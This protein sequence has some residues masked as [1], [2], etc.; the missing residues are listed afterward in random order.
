MSLEDA[1]GQ[2]MMFGFTGTEVTPDIAATLDRIKPG[3]VILY[4]YDGPTG[5]AQPRN[6]VSPEQLQTLTQDLQANTA[7]GYFIAIDAEGGLVNRLKTKYGFTLEVP[8]AEE[9]GTTNP[10][11][12]V[13]VIDELAALLAQM[14]IN[15]NFAPVVD[16]NINP[17]SPAIGNFER[18]FSADPAVVTGHAAA[19]VNALSHHGVISA[20]KHFPGHGSAANDTHLGV[21]DVTDSYDAAAELAPYRNLIAAGYDQPVMTAH[22]VNRNLDPSAMPATLSHP[23]MTMLLRDELGFDGLVVSDDMQ[24]GAIVE[25][26]TL[27]AAVVQA[28][29]AGVDVLLISNQQTDYDLSRLD[30]IKAAVLAAVDNGDISE[31]RIYDSVR[32]ILAL[33]ERYGII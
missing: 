16:V 12:T 24:M 10:T 18:S 23:I 27:E 19:F 14:G 15:W 2:M 3:G 9:L 32:R 29:Q 4:D 8:S 5:G 25:V 17:E 30:R 28:I 7:I 31:Q 1:V 33:K 6:I 21:T 13:A 20:L 22:I 11:N 26:F